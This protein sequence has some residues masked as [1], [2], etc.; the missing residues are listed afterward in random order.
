MEGWRLH[1]FRN[2]SVNVPGREMVASEHASN[3]QGH[4]EDTYHETEKQKNDSKTTRQ[5]VPRH[6]KYILRM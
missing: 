3:L 6:T 4:A 5:Q 1:H 2:T